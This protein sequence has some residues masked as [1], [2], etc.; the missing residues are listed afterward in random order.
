[1]SLATDEQQTLPWHEQKTVEQRVP[2]LQRPPVQHAIGALI[3]AA[4]IVTLCLIAIDIRIGRTVDQFLAEDPFAGT[5]DVFGAPRRLGV[6]DTLTVNDLVPVLQRRGY[7]ETPHA[8]VGTYTVTR[9]AVT[10]APGPDAHSA[11]EPCRIEFFG[12]S[13]A[14]IVSE[15][16]R[17]LPGI[18]LEPELITNVSENRERRRLVK[19]SDIPPRL[20]HAIISVEDK[21]FFDHSGFDLPRM[22]KAAYIDMKSGRKEQGASTLSMQLVRNFWLEPEK[23][24]KRKLQEILLTSHIENRLTKQQIFEYYANQIYLGRVDTYSI[25]GFAEGARAYFGKDLSQLTDAESAL[26]AGLVQRPSYFNPFRYPERATERR[27]LVLNLMYKNGYLGEVEYR[28]AIAAPLGIY[29]N[30]LGTEPSPYFVDLVKEEVENKLDGAERAGRHVYTSLDPQLQSA[31]EAAVHD[32]VQ[33]V[34]RQLRS[35]RLNLSPDQPQVALIALDPRT[36]EVKALVG[37]RNYRTSQLNHVT[38]MRQPG[39]AFKPVV[40]AAALNTAV[41]EGSKLFT[42][43]TVVS[44]EA[45]TFHSGGRDYQAHNFHGEDAGDV[46]LRYALAHSLNIAAV[47]VASAIGFD[48]VVAMARRFG[49]PDTIRATPAVA[50]GAYEATPLQIASAYTAFANDGML[51][52]AAVVSEV[53]DSDGR[54]LY[55]HTPDSR[56]ALDSRVNYLMVNIMQDVL[57]SGT[58]AGARAMGFTQPA[59]GKTGT[60]RDG[61]FAGFTTELVCVVWV[62]FDDNRDL[63]LEGAKSA[64]PIWAEFMKRASKIAPYSNAK[65]FRVPSGIRTVQVCSQSG[66]LAT[67][68]CPNSHSDVFVEGTEPAKAC[69]MH[70]ETVIPVDIANVPE[71]S[72]P[73]PTERDRLP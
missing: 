27:N 43:A 67:A 32:G 10:I 38:A 60:S 62:G 55:E 54:I 39:S 48:R 24:W 20:V 64:L 51:T 5:I 16:G 56:S 14:R 26:L 30:E 45:T 35:R 1:M 3:G 42:P 44:G 25:S 73:P 71:Y 9:N 17:T 63:N 40:Y 53:R 7:R 41:E 2:F 61:W 23:S 70:H 59:A 15:S 50:L 8:R 22:V 6:G 4:S 12:G 66:A 11:F 36:G 18:D 29:R 68:Y 28:N 46:P 58:G 47:N 52:P 34:D 72:I 19:F 13:V 21:K 33:V 65:Q 69:S 49:L 31:A 37:G 57:R